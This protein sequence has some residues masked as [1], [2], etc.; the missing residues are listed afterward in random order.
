[1]DKYDVVFFDL[2]GT[3]TDPSVGIINSVKFALQKFKIKVQ[4]PK[5]LFE[6]I[7]PPLLESFQ[8]YFALSQDQAVIA[9][10]YF[11]EYFK[12]KGIYENQI[13]PGIFELLK[14]LNQEGRT[15]CIATSKPT[16]FAKTVL[17][18]FNLAK[19]CEFIVGSNLD[20]TRT[21]KTDVIQYALSKIPDYRKE[22]IVM[23]GDRKHDIIG[24]Q[25]FNIASIG[26][27]YGFGSCDE[28]QDASPTYIANNVAELSHLLLL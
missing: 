26:V 28:I 9:I 25:H 23:V 27:T 20:L 17:S 6:F 15:I 8:K 2:D 3:L 4:N 13:Y 5:I 11:R 18:H 14:Q 7:G 16:P 19:F 21:S 1:M 10:D 24:A 12:I 22:S